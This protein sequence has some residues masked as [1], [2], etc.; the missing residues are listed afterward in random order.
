MATTRTLEK[1]KEAKNDEFYTRLEDIELELNHYREQ[2][3]D[4]VI[5]CN[6]D[7]PYESSFFKYFAMNFNFFGLK[8]LIAT[9]YDGSIVAGTQLSIFDIIDTE[10]TAYKVE[11]DSISDLNGDGVIDLQDV[12]LLLKTPGVVKQLNENGDFRSP[13]C[14]GLLKEADIVVT[15]P[16]FSLFREFIST[17]VEYNKD[18]IVI[19]NTNA[20]TYKEIFS[21]FMKDKIRTGYT[22]FNSGMFFKIP[23]HYDKFHHIDEKGNKVA[24]V[25]TSCWLTSLPVA[26]HNE[27]LVLYK[28]Y[29]S[30]EYPKYENYNAININK[31]TEIPFDYNGDMGVPVTFLDKFNPKQFEIVGLGISNSGLEIGVSG[32]KA[33]HKKYRK[34]VQNKGAVDGDLYMLDQNGHPV[35]PYAR[36]IIRRKK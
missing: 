35:V 9:C 22:K 30:T 8:K 28:T 7:D 1:A 19:G 11:I 23:D 25:S 15:N 29:N 13:E 18:F 4:K 24:R 10:K 17:L 33:E 12:E 21:L 32:Y 16:P 31:Y 34:E 14:I 20:L 36:I 5:F 26:K 27:E 2:F 3:K 6:C